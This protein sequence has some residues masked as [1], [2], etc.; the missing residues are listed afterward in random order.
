MIQSEE[1]LWA[2][3]AG[4]VDGEGYLGIEKKQRGNFSAVLVVNM[5]CQ[6][7]I[8]KL[9]SIFKQGSIFHRK[10]EGK[11]SDIWSCRLYGGQAIKTINNL[12]AY[13]VTKRKHG[14][15]ISEYGEKCQKEVG[16]N[17]PIPQDI[18]ILRVVIFDELRELNKRGRNVT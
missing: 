1:L 17:Q 4:I 2:W 7:T 6:E 8:H 18:Q 16:H 3:A 12:L 5:T 10:R 11:H 13:L 14:L 15:L 9:R